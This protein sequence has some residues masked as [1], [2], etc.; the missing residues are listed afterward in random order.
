MLFQLFERSTE[1]IKKKQQKNQQLELKKY[2]LIFSDD[3][4]EFQ[5][6]VKRIKKADPG[7]KE[8]TKVTLVKP[9]FVKSSEIE[10]LPC[11]DKDKINFL[12]S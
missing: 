2:I 4:N 12:K 1:F 5:S 9:N 3:I 10:F 7:L 6:S 8:L 11:T